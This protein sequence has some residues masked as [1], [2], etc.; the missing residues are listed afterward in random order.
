LKEFLNR[1]ISGE[2]TAKNVH[3]R[4]LFVQWGTVLLKDEELAWDLAYSM[5]G[6]NCCKSVMLR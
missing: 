4:K 3:F 6:K 5:A 2:V 1:T